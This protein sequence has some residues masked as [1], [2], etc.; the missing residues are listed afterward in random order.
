MEQYI[1]NETFN[2]SFETCD[3]SN[4]IADDDITNNSIRENQ[5]NDHKRNSVTITSF[6]E[7]RKVIRPAPLSEN[8]LADRVKDCDAK[9]SSMQSKFSRTRRKISAT[10]KRNVNSSSEKSASDLTNSQPSQPKILFLF[11]DRPCYPSQI[12]RF[13]IMI[14]GRS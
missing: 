12:L 5:T 13:V 1:S 11:N 3:D 10:K 14:T 7:K 9:V 2:S 6:F 8:Q 4:V